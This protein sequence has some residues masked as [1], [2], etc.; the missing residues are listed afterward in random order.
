MTI[1]NEHPHLV[2][3]DNMGNLIEYWRQF[4]KISNGEY[5]IG[6]GHTKERVIEAAEKEFQQRET[7]LA[8]SDYEKL[9]VL[10]NKPYLLDNDMNEVVKIMGRFVLMQM[11]EKVTQ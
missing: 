8:M 7:Y 9:I 11:K 5:V 6:I 4:R 2:T 1:L 3:T 10:I